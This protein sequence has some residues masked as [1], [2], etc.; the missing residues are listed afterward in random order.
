M[1][2][3]SLL[4]GIYP[5]PA[6]LLVTKKLYLELARVDVGNVRKKSKI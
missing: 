1:K 3:V 6:S 4:S 2:L 5:L